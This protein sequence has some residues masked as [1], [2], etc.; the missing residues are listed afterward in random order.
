VRGSR[1]SRRSAA[2]CLERT[3][4]RSGRSI[5]YRVDCLVY[6]VTRFFKIVGR[7]CYQ[8]ELRGSRFGTALQGDDGAPFSDSPK[9]QLEII[10]EALRDS[11]AIGVIPKEENPGDLEH[12]VSVCREIRKHGQRKRVPLEPCSLEDVRDEGFQLGLGFRHDQFARTVA[13]RRAEVNIAHAMG[14]CRGPRALV[15]RTPRL[16]E[17]G[18]EGIVTRRCAM[19]SP[20]SGARWALLKPLRSARA[21]PA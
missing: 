8:C 18:S 6:D 14:C 1:C 15:E 12:Q 7:T 19:G 9:H 5:V 4:R 3:A 10:L 2:H 20:G 21:D 16:P 17:Y 13:N 11:L